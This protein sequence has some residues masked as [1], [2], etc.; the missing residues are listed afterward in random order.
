MSDY[1]T[2]LISRGLDMSAVVRPRP[3]PLFAPERAVD[4]PI[5]GAA[6]SHEE[7]VAAMPSPR[8]RDH[9]RLASQPPVN[10]MQAQTDQ[11]QPLSDPPLSAAL[12]RRALPAPSRLIEPSA[13]IAQPSETVVPARQPAPIMPQPLPSVAV[14]QPL[15]PPVSSTND[16]P[17]DGDAAASRLS[18]VPATQ[19]ILIERAVVSEPSHAADARHPALPPLVVA[20]PPVSARL[21]IQPEPASQSPQ[22]IVQPSI[23]PALSTFQ[24]APRSA[25][26]SVA[27]Q[28]A[29]TTEPT[30]H[31][32]IGRIEVRATSPAPAARPKSAPAPTMSL[33][34][35]LR[36]R[37]GGRR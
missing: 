21:H 13:D 5:F 35:Y 6:E 31:V 2:R 30:I 9:R 20:Q 25:P 27:S 7:T 1:L 26:P 15:P 4:Q 23:T 33:D 37:G 36:T 11:L 17:P 32:T 16:R 29:A 12:H 28:P 34:D 19:P 24:T 18:P 10:M 14:A 22:I 3:T 8:Q